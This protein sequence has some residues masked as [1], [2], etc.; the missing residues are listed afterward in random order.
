MLNGGLAGQEGDDP[1]ENKQILHGSQDINEEEN[2]NQ[3]RSPSYGDEEEDIH[4]EMAE[5]LKE[6]NA[7]P[8]SDQRGQQELEGEDEEGEGS[9]G[10]DGGEL[11]D[12]DKLNDQEK[13]ILLHYL[14]D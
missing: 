3:K 8:D 2:D 1:N 10:E 6:I 4:Q 5:K 12:I 7:E 13:A 9:S 14:Q 11:I